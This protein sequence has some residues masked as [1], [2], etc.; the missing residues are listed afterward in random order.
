MKL[1]GAVLIIIAGSLSG[2]S[3]A[4]RFTERC[5]VLRLWIR[6]CEIL[7]IEIGY[8]ARLLPEVFKIVARIINDREMAGIFQELAQAVEYGAAGDTE[9]AWEQILSRTWPGILPEVDWLILSELGS[10]LGSTSREHQIQQLKTS[11]LRLETNLR[12]AETE[13]DQKAGLF[14]YLGFAISAALVLF[15][16]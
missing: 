15:I 12:A 16:L 4:Y 3:Y 6:V 9:T 14:R 7:I 10:Y 5:R 2:I 13:R 11:Q 8:Q 1:A